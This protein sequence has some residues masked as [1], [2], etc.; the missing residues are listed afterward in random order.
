MLIGPP[1][2][3]ETFPNLASFESSLLLTQNFTHVRERVS[4]RQEWRSW[5]LLLNLPETQNSNGR[6][7]DVRLMLAPVTVIINDD[8]LLRTTISAFE[9]QQMVALRLSQQD[10]AS[11]FQLLDIEL[12]QER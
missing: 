11:D 3:L 7:I 4:G 9:K 5:L 8:N 1:P 2:Y 6:S 10:Q 12:L